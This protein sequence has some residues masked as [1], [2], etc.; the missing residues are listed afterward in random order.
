MTEPMM[1]LTALAVA[2]TPTATDRVRLGSVAAAWEEG[3]AAARQAAPAEVAAGGALFDPR[4]VLP[5]A[6]PP[7]GTYRCRIVKLGAKSPGLLAYVAYP[8][9]ACRVSAGDRER[10][11]AKLTGSQRF[12]GVLRPARDDRAMFLGTLRYGDEARALP[13]GRDRQRDMAGWVER[14][15]DKR[16]RLALPYP[17]FESVV[18]VV[19]L[20]PAAN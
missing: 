15:G 11:I 19:E 12:V 4:V 5:N 13:Y 9:F 20:V 3:L 17:A 18:D 2:T 6:M 14:I 7:A 8:G 16:W 1:V 10:R